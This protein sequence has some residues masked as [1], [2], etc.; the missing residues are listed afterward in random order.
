MDEPSAL[1]WHSRGR[2]YGCLWAVGACIVCVC[3]AFHTP[4]VPTAA[5]LPFLCFLFFGFFLNHCDGPNPH[6]SCTKQVL[7]NVF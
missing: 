4:K 6:M 2:G 3:C 5:P 1:L 7:Y